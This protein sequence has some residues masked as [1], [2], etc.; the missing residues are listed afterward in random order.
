MMML[1][2]SCTISETQEPGLTGVNL[3]A[4]TMVRGV[5]NQ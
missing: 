1:I 3:K 5:Q 4:K 2:P